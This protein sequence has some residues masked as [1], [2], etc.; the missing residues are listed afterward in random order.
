MIA[1]PQPETEP[2]EQTPRVV[3]SS[4]DAPI[5][6]RD[7]APEGDG[8]VELVVGEDVRGTLDSGTVSRADLRSAVFVPRDGGWSEVRLGL[9]SAHLRGEDAELV[10][11]WLETLELDLPHGER[12]F[13]EGPAME[14]GAITVLESIWDA[15][16]RVLGTLLAPDAQPWIRDAWASYQLAR[17]RPDGA[18]QLVERYVEH[19]ARLGRPIRDDPAGAL[20]ASFCVDTERDSRDAPIDPNVLERWSDLRG[21]IDVDECLARV[22]ARIVAHVVPIYDAASIRSFFRGAT[23]EGMPPT[24]VRSPGPLRPGDVVT[25]VR[26]ERLESL[27]ALG[28]HIGRLEPRHRVSIAVER[29]EQ[30]VR[31]WLRVPSM[32]VVREEVVFEILPDPSEHPRWPFQ[33]RVD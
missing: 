7:R 1:H 5:S 17:R 3:I 26:G 11:T 8:E 33:T 24:V 16:V 30:T 25:H 18:A 22:D 15:R 19:R 31:M 12:F 6:G 29:G 4:L 28:R 13:V 20:W 9:M 2:V 14:D 27:D 10:A 23:V 32:E 21:V